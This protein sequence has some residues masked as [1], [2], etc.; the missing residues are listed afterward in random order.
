MRNIS[1][2][3]LLFALR[4]SLIFLSSSLSGGSSAP[5]LFGATSVI[6]EAAGWPE[7]P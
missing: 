1:Q 6:W 5:H 7:L 3:G 4:S 2:A